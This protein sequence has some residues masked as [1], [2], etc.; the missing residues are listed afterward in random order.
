MSDDT[1]SLDQTESIVRR[2]YVGEYRET[3]DVED[4]TEEEIN[5]SSEDKPSEEAATSTEDPST[6]DVATDSEEATTQTSPV[7]P[8]AKVWKKRYDDARR[9][10]NTLVD[11]NKR[12]ETQLAAK[13]DVPLPKSKE[14]IAAWKAKYPDVYDIVSSIS[15]LRAEEQTT[16]MKKELKEVGEAQEQV[17]FDRAY[18]Q[19]VAKH[20]D[21]DELV[22]SQEFH[23]WANKQPKTIQQSLYENRSDS[24]AAIRAIDLYKYDNK[25]VKSK[26]DSKKDA[27]KAVTKTKASEPPE[28]KGPKIWTEAEIKA[29]SER[30]YE[31]LEAEIDIAAREGRVVLS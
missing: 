27:A 26:T 23:D 21:F 16:S 9:H 17:T 14:E 7:E 19:I 18:N 13:G 25:P 8:E 29:L 28:G 2:P 3:L 4:K 6:D 20:P 31:K 10:H 1:N 22:A 11:K 15:A 30:E 5:V 24:A 12:L